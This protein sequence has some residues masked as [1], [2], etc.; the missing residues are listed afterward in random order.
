[1]GRVTV[2]VVGP[3]AAGKSTL[4]ARLRALGYTARAIAQEHSFVPDM[5]QRLT[6]P[7]V[8]I[9]L[10]VSFP[11]AQARRPMPWR[12][13]DFEEQQRRLQHARAHADPIIHT[14]PL[15]P[16]EVL[17]QA[18]AFLQS[19]GL[20]PPRTTPSQAKEPPYP[21]TTPRE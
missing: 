20:P 5:W 11:V 21:K 9:Y 10:E 2:G 19:R 4:V 6:Q 1:M 8:L 15:T 14:D 7:A 16:D 3:C 12:E 17:Q 13:E 18:V